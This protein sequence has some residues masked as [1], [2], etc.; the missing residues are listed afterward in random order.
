MLYKGNNWTYLLASGYMYTLW[1][2]QDITARYCKI[3]QDSARWCNLVQDGARWC[4]MV[5]DGATWC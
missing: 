3:V 1:V 4:K 5:Q 2:Q